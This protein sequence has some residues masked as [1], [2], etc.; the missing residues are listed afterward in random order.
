MTRLPDS[1]RR[2]VERV[3]GDAAEVGAGRIAGVR[4]VG[5]GCINPSARVE[6]E[7]GDAFFLKWNADADA[8][9]FEVEA[10][11][12]RALVEAGAPLRVPRPVAVG[13]PETPD[14]PAWLL[15]EF[16][17]TGGAAAERDRGRGAG[18]TDAGSYGE[19]L[20][21]GLAE[22]HRDGAR[23]VAEARGEGD[24]GRHGWERDNVIGSL[25][26]ANDPEGDWGRFWRERRLE[27][28]LRRAR[29]GGFLRGGRGE[30]LDRLLAHLDEVLAGTGDEAPSLLHGDLWSGNAF[31][32]PGGEPVLIDPAVYRG[33]REVDLAMT[34]LF[35]G[36]PASF[37]P[38]Y[39]EVLPLEPGYREV[40]RPA[41]Q[42]YYLL[43]HVNLFGAGYVG[44]TVAAAREALAGV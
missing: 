19:R 34:E 14:E 15:M 32:G 17:P 37:L 12:L 28:Q 7:G 35:G 27:P 43:V 38:A 26:Q 6:T 10:D 39:E 33:H 44:R 30:P 31:P 40:R 8:S 36:F 24:P 3:L 5:G 13:A 20:G 29:D 23:R 25:P 41:Y 11:G 9:F 4:S 42:L 2:G 18:S 22:L 21:R 16:V 1:V